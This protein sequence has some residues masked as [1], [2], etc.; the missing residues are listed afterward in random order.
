MI[1][2]PGFYEISDE[3]YFAHPAVSNSDLKM[4]LRS[5]AHYRHYKDNPTEPT[6][7]M[8]AG[9]ALHCAI[10]EPDQFMSRYAIIPDNA[11]ARPTAAMLNAKNPK[12]ESLDRIQ[13]WQQ[14]D[15]M[16]AG[17]ELLTSEKAAEYLHIGNTVRTHPSL[18][19]LFDQGQPEMAV[20]GIDPVTGVLCKCKIDLLCYIQSEDLRIKAEIKTTD[21][22]RLDAFTR[23]SL[24]YGYYQGCAFYSDVLKFAD[25]GAPDLDMIVA[26]ER[27]APYGMALYEIP[28]EAYEYGQRRYREALDLYAKCLEADEWPNYAPEP[29]LLSLP[30]W[31]KE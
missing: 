18:E 3:E 13:Y 30:A 11:P 6:P 26:I 14:F 8:K 31:I 20:F 19:V 29:V 22:A 16:N 17:K 4:V 23:T 9:T 21:D 5:P 25:I 1:K 15:A 27:S 28:P 7:A 2:E 12:Q 10:L 24:K